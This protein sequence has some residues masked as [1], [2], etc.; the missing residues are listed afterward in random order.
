MCQC[1]KVGE[2]KL[3]R[4]NKLN[5]FY[6]TTFPVTRSKYGSVIL[7]DVGDGKTRVLGV[8]WYILQTDVMT[9]RIHL[10]DPPHLLK[11]SN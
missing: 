8:L 4:G 7:R 1:L 3:D 10:S 2:I 5:L 9:P 11:A 6:E